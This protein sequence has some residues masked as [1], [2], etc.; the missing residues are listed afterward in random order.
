MVAGAGGVCG[1]CQNALFYSYGRVGHDAD[2]RLVFVKVSTDISE[3]LACGDGNDQCFFVDEG[4]NLRAGFGHGLWFDAEPYLIALLE[5]VA[6]GAMIGGVFMCW[7]W[8]VVDMR[9][10]DVEF[11]G[12][13]YPA[14]VQGAAHIAIADYADGVHGI[15]S[16]LVY[17]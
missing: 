7:F 13:I 16:V 15:R 9:A 2:N 5:P 4:F 17:P 12:G 6:S 10:G 1:D 3:G 11:A 8:S 14:V